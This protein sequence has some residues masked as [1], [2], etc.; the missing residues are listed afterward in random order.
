MSLQSQHSFSSIISVNPYKDIYLNGV[1]SFLAPT[2]TPE[3]SKDQFA[4]S[5]INTKGFINAQIEISKNIPN[6]DLYDAINSKAYYELALDQ[7][8]E[9]QIQYIETFQNLDEENRHFHVFI[10][11]PLDIT[12]TFT[13]VIEKIKYLDIIV[14][15]PLLI[16][17]LYSKEIIDSAGIHSFIYIQE[18]DAFITIYKDK[19]FI[20]TKSIKFSLIEMHERFCEL[21]GERID[22]ESFLSFYANTNLKET[23]SDYKEYFIKLYKELFANVNDILT[24]AKRAFEIEKFEHVYIGSQL[25]SVT[26]LDEMLEVEL[27]IKSSEFN[28][29]YGYESDDKYV[30]Q[31]H[32][33]MHI[34]TTLSE[35]ERYECNFSTYHRPPAFI[36]RE[37]GKIIL[38]T[39]ASFALAFA[40]P[41][42][43]WTL[44][45]AQSLQEDLLKQDYK[46]V[47]N[48]KTTRQSTLKSKEADKTKALALLKIE[49]D[50]YTNKKNTLVKIHDV[51]VNY[52]MK[53]KLISTFTKDLNRHNVKMESLFYNE[54]N[55][56]K[57]FSFNLVSSKDRRITKLVQDLTK[58]YENSFKFELNSISYDE[59]SK[60][61][62]SQLKVNIL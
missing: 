37:S 19:E 11:D 35:E 3:F 56:T 55:S 20:Y 12:H 5:Y 8:V 52:P 16:K 18:N 25:E 30:D 54:T 32:A 58:R 38:L 31:L 46:E 23:D 49:Q 10:V 43:Y 15:V 4:L 2:T 44:N 24:Y 60:V 28:F 51:K 59:K 61:Y 17:S 9:Y 39:A 22:Y 7:A 50:E 33:L 47:H 27:N 34:Y 57:T 48:K 45:Y 41:V 1:S 14:P 6:E 13:E 26:K 21:Y 53:A 36:K 42:T 62:F 29:D 40:Y